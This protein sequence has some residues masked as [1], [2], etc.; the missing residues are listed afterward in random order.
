MLLKPERINQYGASIIQ[1]ARNHPQGIGAVPERDVLTGNIAFTGFERLPQAEETL[2]LE[3]TAELL[4]RHDLGFREMGYLVFPS[5]INVTRQAPDEAHPR[6]EVA[7]RFSGSIET[8]YASLVVR[9]SYT[10]YFRRE[11]QWKYAVEFSRDGN[12]LGFSMRQ[13]EE[14]HGRTGDL[15]SARHQRVRPGD[16]Y[17]VCHRS[18]CE[19]RASISRNRFGF[20]VLSVPREVT[21]REAIEARIRDGKL[22]IP[23]QFCETAVVI[24][25]SVEEIYQRDPSLGKKQQQLAKTVEQRTEAE[26]KQFRADQR[27]YTAAE[28]HRIHILHLSDLHLRRRH[29]RERLPDT[30]GNR[31]DPGTRH[32]AAGIS[33][34]LRRRCQPL[35]RKGI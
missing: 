2:V 32:P 33:D 29:V 30:T 8:I 35:N 25:K 20:I 16:V 31:S 34:H 3:G 1:A 26:V 27:Q 4:I 23:C 19:P 22:D 17:P 24:P 11:D 12:R 18:P 13:I 10:N 7:Y 5:Q 28:D 14:G 6:T 9:L 15:F 21:N